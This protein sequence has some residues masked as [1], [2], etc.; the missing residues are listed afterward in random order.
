MAIV[1]S[2]LTTFNHL[3]KRVIKVVT[4]YQ[5]KRFDI[6]LCFFKQDSHSL[7]ASSK[8]LF[9]FAYELDLKAIMQRHDINMVVDVGANTGQ[10]G[11][12]L[13][14]DVGYRGHM[15]SFEPNR[16]AYN[17]LCAKAKEDHN[18]KVY[19][20]ALG[21][22][23]SV[24]ELCIPDDSSLASFLQPNS[25]SK[26]IFG[27]AATVSRKEKIE[28]RKSDI[29]FEFIESLDSH[30]NIFLKLDTQGYDLEVVRGLGKKVMTLK[31]FQSEVSIIPIYIGMPT[32]VES[33]S[34]FQHLGFELAGLYPVSRDRESFGVIEYDSLFVN[35]SANNSRKQSL[36]GI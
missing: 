16:A 34:H 10:F 19:N 1:K 30:S 6:G 23:D 5:T 7:G 35:K 9:S 14:R 31:L 18:W 15:I 2:R 25:Y 33:L 36:T 21:A 29:I 12:F 26:E 27:E 3:I 28:I 32:W 13:R 8:D 11:L 22:Q 17:E 20:M 24:A 4:G